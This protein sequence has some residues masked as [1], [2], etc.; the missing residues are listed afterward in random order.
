MRMRYLPTLLFVFLVSLWLSS[1]PVHAQERL[2]FTRLLAHWAEYNH[3]D[4]LPFVL[5]AEPDVVQLG[6]YGGHFW[7]LAHTDAFGG[8]PA[9]FPVQG[10]NE[11]GAWFEEKNKALHAKNIKVVGHYNV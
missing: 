3:P 11:S 10:L 9:H 8:Y 5:E 7:S 2:E 4:Y 1:R 6:F